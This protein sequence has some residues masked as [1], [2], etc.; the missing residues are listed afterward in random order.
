LVQR[1]FHNPVSKPPMF[2]AGVFYDAGANFLIPF[3]D[4]NLGHG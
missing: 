1:L 2:G 3:N 4:Y